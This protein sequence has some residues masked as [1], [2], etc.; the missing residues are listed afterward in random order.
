MTQRLSQPT[1][2]KLKRE[3]FIHQIRILER[4]QEDILDHDPKEIPPPPPPPPPHIL[5]FLPGVSQLLPSFG[6]YQPRCWSER[7]PKRPWEKVSHSG[8]PWNQLPERVLDSRVHWWLCWECSSEWRG[9]SLHP[10]RR[11]QKDKISLAT[12][13]HSTN[14]EAEAEAQKTAAAH[15]EA[16]THASPNV[17]PHTGALSVLQAFQ[18][19]RDTEPNDLSVALSSLCRGHAV[20][21]QWIPY[22]CKRAWQWG[23]WLSGK[24]RH[25][26]GA[27]LRWRPS[28]R[29]SN[30]ASGGTSTHGTTRLTP[31]TF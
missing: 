30:T 4:R 29:P 1:K 7:L 14:Y 8:I 20:T 17:V 19:S 27:T 18:S 23:C 24:G 15:F 9:R 6:L 10:V 12:G 26:K 13:L 2:G 5:P 11:R 16:I 3:S 28:L 22:H 25:N 21:L 31:T